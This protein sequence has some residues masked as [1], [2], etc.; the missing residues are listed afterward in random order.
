M[1]P[2][3]IAFIFVALAMAQGPGKPQA[4]PAHPIVGFA[5]SKDATPI[6]DTDVFDEAKYV[7]QVGADTTSVNA[8]RA[9]HEATLTREF[10]DGFNDS[11]ECDNVILNG[12]GDNKP[13][14]ALQIIVDS[15]D[16]PNQK[17]VWH[18]ILRDL[19][20]NKLLPVGNDDTGK[21]AARSI[22]TAVLKESRI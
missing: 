10:M 11:K 1:K 9:A 14:F 5:Q 17:P 20:S 7:E 21:Q 3:I 13:D 22:C 8:K 15:H 18:Y 16:T 4:E 12:K 6:M 2:T 19:H